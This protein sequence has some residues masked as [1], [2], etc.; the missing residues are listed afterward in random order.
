MFT[1]V[2]GLSWQRQQRATRSH[3]EKRD[4]LVTALRLNQS[5]LWR[6]SYPNLF[7]DR[8]NHYA[9]IRMGHHKEACGKDWS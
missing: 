9:P 8:G 1:R 2:C 6:A 5:R 7:L 3:R 4:S